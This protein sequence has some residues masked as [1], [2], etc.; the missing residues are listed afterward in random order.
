[1]F[2]KNKCIFLSYKNT[3]VSLYYRYKHTAEVN[4]TIFRMSSSMEKLDRYNYQER[5]NINFYSIYNKVSQFYWFQIPYL[6]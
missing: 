6:F 4:V 5:N 2:K 1:M 3:A